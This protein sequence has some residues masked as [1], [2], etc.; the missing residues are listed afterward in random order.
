M[1]KKRF[2][3]LANLVADIMQASEPYYINGKISDKPC[4]VMTVYGH[5]QALEIRVYEHGIS[6]GTDADKAFRLFMAGMLFRESVYIECISYLEGIRSE[7]NK[8]A[9]G[10]AIPKGTK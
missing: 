5:V 10:T 3:R 2:M 8:S 9:Q 6:S 7:L 1:T 4:V